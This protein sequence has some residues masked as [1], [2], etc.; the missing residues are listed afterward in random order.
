MGF[1]G[2]TRIYRNFPRNFAF[3]M[4]Q[5]LHLICLVVPAVGLICSVSYA[6]INAPDIFF[7]LPCIHLGLLYVAYMMQIN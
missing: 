7:Y 1:W 6:V 5:V 4:C 3:A 2:K